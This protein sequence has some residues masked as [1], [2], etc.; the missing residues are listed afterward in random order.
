MELAIILGAIS[1]GILI[2]IFTP[3]GE[4]EKLYKEKNQG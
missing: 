3:T 2:A 4:K 1:V